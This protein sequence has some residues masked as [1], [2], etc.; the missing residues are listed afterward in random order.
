MRLFKNRLLNEYKQNEKLLL[1]RYD[2]YLDF[3]EKKE[4]IY[5]FKEEE[6]QEGFLKDIFEK[7]LGYTLKTTNPKS[8]N[9]VREL[10]SEVD[11][12]KSDGAIVVD[13]QVVGVI[14]LKDTKTK[15]LDSV[16]IQAFNYLNSHTFAKYVIISNFEKLRFYIEKRTAYEEFNLFE[17]SFEDFKRFHTI[18]SFESIKNHIPLKLK[19][20]SI[21]F[22]AEIT[23][24]LYRDYQEFRLQLF[25]N[26]VKN[27]PHKQKLK[28]LN[29]TQKLCD[30][31]VF[32]LF[33]EDRGLLKPNTIREIRE[34]YKDD[35]F[36]YT[37][38]DYYKIYFDAIDK[39]NEKLQIPRYNG[40]LFA[41]DEELDNLKID[42][43]SLNL[44]A[45]KLSDYD[46]LSDIDVNILGHIFEQSLNDLEELS[47]EIENRTFQKKK[48]KRKKD[49]VFY[50]PKYIVEYILNE[51]LGTLCKE[52][53]EAL[54]IL[55]A[56]APKNPKK[57][58]KKELKIKN[59]LLE[60]KEW[61]FNLKILDPACGSGAFL[62]GCLEFL[63]KEHKK[64][65]EKLSIMGD[66]TAY[67]DVEVSILEHN[68]Y[69]VDINYEAV[70]IARLSLWLRSAQKGRTLPYKSYYT[71][72][73][74]LI[75]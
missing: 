53:Q 22:E 30:R 25:E 9:L 5:R 62:N 73:L 51:T 43:E 31:I 56:T 33:C 41:K 18:L 46:F 34:R 65:Q 44:K 49:G 45:Q 13:G 8:Y 11:S 39:G 69:G 23:K 26:I 24:E 71:I 2:A 10:K 6:Y 66:I 59:A 16:E 72:T 32:I 58:T 17:L 70:E 54:N 37:L 55:E 47:S 27:N 57:P 4:A 15:N 74:W 48:S 29:L 20:K 61:L 67:Y 68:L 36:G 7:A 52:K 1:K 21:N 50:T 14:E 38:Y 63:I 35:I 28:L 12:K 64:L 60:Y 19:E 75:L 42:D 40:G 3:I